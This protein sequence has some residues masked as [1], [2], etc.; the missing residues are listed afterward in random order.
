MIAGPPESH[1]CREIR[2][3][4]GANKKKVE[5][6]NA[7]VK[8]VLL[9]S[10]L[11]IGGQLYA[12]DQT[13]SVLSARNTEVPFSYV[14]GG[15]RSWPVFS[16]T[17]P[18]SDQVILT[19]RD[20]ELVLANGKELT[21]GGLQITLSRKG[22]LNIKSA[23]NASEELSLEISVQRNGKSIEQQRINVR[24]APPNRPI[25]YVSDLVDDLIRIFWDSSERRF[26]PVTK[27]SFDQ[28]FRRLQAQGITR[29]IV[30]QSAFPLIADPKIYGEKEWARFRSQARAILDSKALNESMRKTAPLKSYEWLGLL[31]RLRMDTV[32]DR[33]FMTSAKEHGIRLTA[34]FRPFEA[35]LTKYYEVPAFADDGTWLWGFLP[36][37]TPTV[38]YHSDQVS[39][40]N[41]REILRRMG[42][43][44]EATLQSIEIG[45]LAGAQASPDDFELVASP[46]PPL[47]E[48]SFVLVRQS[49]G[50]F[51]LVLYE[52]IQEKVEANW[53]RLKDARFR[54][55]GDRLT[56]DGFKVPDS[57][58]YL[59]LRSASNDGDKVE[60]PVVPDVTL[61][62][63]AG[64]RLGRS[65]VYCSLNGDSPEARATRVVGIPQTGLYH[66][67]FQAIEKSVDYFRKTKEKHWRLGD[68]TLVIDRGARWS[69]EMTDFNRP[70]ARKFV[71]AELKKIL[72]YDAFD[73]IIINTRSHTQLSGST[74]DGV[75]GVRPLAHY[76]VKGTN[77]YHYG[78]DRAFAPI[79]L[80][81][82]DRIRSAP[83]E[84]ITTFQKGEWIGP[85]QNKES[86]LVWRYQ[87][88]K[89][90]ADGVRALLVDL[91]KSFPKTRIR[92]VIPEGES[93]ILGTQDALAD[94]QKP[95]RGVY[96]RNYYRHIRGSLNHIPGIGEGMAM[97][98]LTGLRV[99]PVFLGI[100]FAP[101]KA[102]LDAFLQRAI[103]D[104]ANN[105][106]SSYR[107]PKSFFYEAQ[108]TLRGQNFKLKRPRREEIICDLLRHDA[109]DE[110]LLY[111]AADWTYYL[112]LSDR[113]LSSHAFI[114]KCPQ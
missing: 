99:E 4:V 57:H 61:R 41:Y 106:G 5:A 114:D 98:D 103:K 108:E 14:V 101:D 83:V 12:D 53:I 25:S 73:E 86:P 55:E 76:R 22:F 71:V 39:F 20:M 58:R 63:A 35:A 56:I 113:D 37:A 95:D 16:G 100:R 110:V 19:A 10:L 109:I 7:I 54:L 46:V 3:P 96:G 75:H 93:V 111:E 62:A 68:G 107:G 29:L 104:L 65:N 8:V 87:R 34:S 64:N 18:D 33:M 97:V 60:L 69:V 17:L 81:D 42:K 84:Q 45:G 112:P 30:W 24:P 40:A 26:R 92:A 43:A 32:F 59:L 11:L 90:I 78:I 70:A 82:H 13:S 1:C 28:Y 77:Y 66:T 15:S 89:A 31:M 80:A 88:N 50:D 79:S 72:A 85:C 6:M 52:N 94:M 67:E 38:N 2:N 48:E 105:R 91:E 44:D 51:Q 74:A 36:G 47:D 23:A 102:P 49:D 9:A 21:V 27:D